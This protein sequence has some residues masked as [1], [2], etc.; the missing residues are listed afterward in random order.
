MAQ[1]STDY[2]RLQELTEEKERIDAELDEKMERFLELQ[3]LVES[4]Q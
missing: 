2:V 4:F 1:V 3:E